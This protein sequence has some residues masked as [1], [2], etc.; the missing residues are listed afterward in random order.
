LG[1]DGGGGS[2]AVTVEHLS[3][4]FITSVMVRIAVSTDSDD[5]YAI[6]A[7]V[8]ALEKKHGK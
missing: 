6:C 5:I 7:C 2:G 4:W 3:E 1:Q 8:K